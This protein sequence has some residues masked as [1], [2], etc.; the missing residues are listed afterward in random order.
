MFLPWIYCR[1]GR[2]GGG[3]EHEKPFRHGVFST[4]QPALALRYTKSTQR[5]H[6]VLLR[7]GAI[8]V[9]LSTGGKFESDQFAYNASA[10]KNVSSGP[11]LRQ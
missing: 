10:A 5:T 7:D 11:G 4:L 3:E 2:P 6:E 9:R 1:F 8:F